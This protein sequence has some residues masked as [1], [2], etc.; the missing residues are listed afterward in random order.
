MREEKVAYLVYWRRWKRWWSFGWPTLPPLLFVSLFFFLVRSV[1]RGEGRLVFCYR[2]LG[3]ILKVPLV[4]LCPSPSPCLPCFV[5]ALPLLA[6]VVFFCVRLRPPS[7]G[8]FLLCSFL[9][10]TPLPSAF[11][12]WHRYQVINR[13]LLQ[14]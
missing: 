12:L 10:S 13:L 7:T 2:V 14:E 9:P 6:P 5:C 3:K 8:F 11:F 4:S 1:L